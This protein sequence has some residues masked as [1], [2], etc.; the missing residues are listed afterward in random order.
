MTHDYKCNGTINLFAAL[1]IATGEVITQCRERH[2]A[3]DVLAFFKVIDKQVPRSL[4]IHV[5][6]D[7]LSAH[8]APEVSRWLAHPQRARWHLHFTPMSSSWLNLVKRWFKELTDRRLRCG[9][10]TSVPDLIEAITTWTEHRDTTP[11][12]PR[13]PDVSGLTPQGG[14]SR[15]LGGAGKSAV[16]LATVDF[17]VAVVAGR[18][19]RADPARGRAGRH[20]RAV[21]CGPSRARPSRAGRAI[22]VV[23]PHLRSI[24]D[25]TAR[26]GRRTLDRTGNATETAPG[27]ARP[28]G[29]VGP[30]AAQHARDDS[31]LAAADDRAARRGARRAARL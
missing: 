31:E 3:V 6:L 2:A 28:P 23:R 24:P 29:K 11:A 5:V 30:G 12:T 8:K 9:V 15:A 21:T 10:F 18:R 4:D 7:N 22:Q 20:V 25:R 14:G 27:L 16:A 13:H 1:D 19:R 26:G 17:P